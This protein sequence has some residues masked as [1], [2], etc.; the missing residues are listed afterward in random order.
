MLPTGNQTIYKT[1]AKLTNRE[2]QVLRLTMDGYSHSH[3]ADALGIS[4]RTVPRFRKRI[5]NKYKVNNVTALLS[6]IIKDLETEVSYLR[7]K[8]PTCY[9]QE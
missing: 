8:G 3:I 4:I 6:I 7:Q 1:P 5:F 2:Q 9:L